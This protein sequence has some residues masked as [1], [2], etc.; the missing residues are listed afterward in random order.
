MSTVSTTAKRAGRRAAHGDGIEYAG[1]LGLV[2]KG[3]S[4][5]LIGVLALQIPLGQGGQVSD[6]QGVLRELATESWGKAALIGLT[7]GFAAYALWRFAEALF[8]RGREGTDAK[9]VAKRARSFGIGVLYAASAVLAAS[10]VTSSS[11]G[12]GTGN[13]QQETA[14]VLEWPGGRWIVLAVAAGFLADGV[15]NV[16]RGATKKFRERLA[17]HE[18]HGAVRTWGVR[19]GVVGHVARGVVFALVGVFLGKAALEYDPQ[20]AVGIDGALLKLVE[21][22]LGPVLLGVVAAGL[23][24]YAV[25]CLVEARFREI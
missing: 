19:S 24:A 13:E 25:Y 18:M 12:S 1:R 6:R 22:P 15:Y 8:D 3:A 23:V 7:V 17:E 5:A 16:Y 4:Y 11:S 9:G 2:A 21:A 10:L 20:E 14:R